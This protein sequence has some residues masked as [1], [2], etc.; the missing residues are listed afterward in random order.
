MYIYSCNRL[1]VKR[2]RGMSSPS[3]R[4]SANDERQREEIITNSD[5]EK[6]ITRRRRSLFRQTAIGMR[7]DILEMDDEE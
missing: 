2:E 6:K 7:S 1:N 3:N 5:G 4:L